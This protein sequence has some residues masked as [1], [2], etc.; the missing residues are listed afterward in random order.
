M[1]VARDIDSVLTV[2]LTLSIRKTPR[3]N[4]NRLTLDRNESS[5]SGNNS[6]HNFKHRTSRLEEPITAAVL[7]GLW[8]KSDGVLTNAAFS[9]TSESGCRRPKGDGDVMSLR[10]APTLMENDGVVLNPPL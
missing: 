6:N 9:I 3:K 7:R 5:N 4:C 1:R 2:R 8:S 10:L